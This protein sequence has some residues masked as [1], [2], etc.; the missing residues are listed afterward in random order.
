[1][2]WGIHYFITNLK[3][4]IDV[5]PRSCFNHIIHIIKKWN[6]YNSAGLGA[7]GLILGATWSRGPTR[8]DA[9]WGAECVGRTFVSVAAILTE[10]NWGQLVIPTG[11]YSDRSIFRQ[12]YIPTGLSSDRSIFRQVVIPTGLCS[13]R[14]IFRQIV[15]P[16][17]RYSDRSLFRQVYIPTCRYSNRSIFRQF[18][19]VNYNWN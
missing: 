13:D 1:M 19:D 2:I 3:T 15:I 5:I 6:L 14:S 12:V 8:I 11:R 17:G 4:K 9:P 18:L 16:T 7:R 10:L